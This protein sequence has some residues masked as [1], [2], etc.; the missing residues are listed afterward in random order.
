MRDILAMLRRSVPEYL[1]QREL[2]R[3]AHMHPYRGPE[4]DDATVQ[5][6]IDAV[7]SAASFPNDRSGTVV[8]ELV[9]CAEVCAAGGDDLRRAILIDYVNWVAYRHCGLDLALYAKD[10][11]VK[12][13]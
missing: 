1:A 6:Q 4:P 2:A 3:N 5:A 7:L 13:A 11:E 10:L 9:R 12:G 8:N